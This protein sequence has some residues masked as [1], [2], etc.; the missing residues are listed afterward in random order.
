VTGRGAVAVIGGGIVG[1]SCALH[2]I[3]RGHGV[4]LLDP[5]EA[6]RGASFG[7]AGVISRGSLFPVAGPGF[8]PKLPRYALNRDPALALRY[9]ALPAALPWLRHFLQR[10]NA[11][12]WREAASALAPLTAA[13]YA[14]HQ[15]L[16]QATGATALIRRE[17][18]LK[19]FRTEAAFAGSIDEREILAL[20]GVR[21]ELLDGD[22]VKDLEPALTRRFARG[23]LVP[24]SG[25]VDR[26]G[27]LLLRYRAAFLYLGGTLLETAADSLEVNGDGVMVRWAGG[28]LL[29]GTAVLAAG[30]WS[31][32]LLRPLG[33]RLPLA[34]ERGYHRHYRVEQP[35]HRPVHDT[36]G[37]YVLSPMGDGTVRLLS[38]IEIARPDDPPNPRQLAQVYPEAA[39]TLALGE[40]VEAEPWCGSR[41]STPD[42]LPVIG[43]APRHPALILALGHGHIGL[44]TG[45]IT[46]RV[47]ADLV[48]RR[49]PPLP[50]GPFAPERFA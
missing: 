8:W 36:G 35:L 16:A 9:G 28:S 27:E 4:T 29:A 1:L 5:G 3:M 20:H 18:Y 32:T 11:T 49:T 44:S 22:A 31:D 15:D 47:V 30:A 34:A 42:G 7:N 12:A 2:L 33:Y 14:A 39:A 6:R 40:P 48:E 46:G 38:G 13:A 45:P 37:A 43:R 19:L 23:L 17:G 10:A 41:P 25:A 26:P 21:T 24:D 50:I